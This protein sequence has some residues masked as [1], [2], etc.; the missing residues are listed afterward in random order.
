MIN[1]EDLIHMGFES[2]VFDDYEFMRLK[3]TDYDYLIGDITI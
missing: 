1:K 2:M 3:I